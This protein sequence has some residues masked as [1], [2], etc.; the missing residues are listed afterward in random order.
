MGLLCGPIG[1]SGERAAERLV[2]G[3]ES[4]SRKVRLDT[5]ERL[6]AL[7]PSAVE[8]LIKA[9]ETGNDTV[10]YVGAQ[11][12][13]RIGDPRATEAL[14]RLTSHRHEHIRAVATEALGR[15]GDQQAVKPLIKGLTDP[16]AVV[17][18][19]AA[20]G[21]GHLR[22]ESAVDTLIGILF[23]DTDSEVRVNVI[24][25]L[26]MIHS[27][28]GTAR[29]SDS[30]I[31]A[32]EKAAQDSDENVR[33]VAVQCLGNMR[34]LTAVSILIDRL[35]DPNTNIRQE[36][37]RALGKIGDLRAVE[38][39]TELFSRADADEAVVVEKALENLTGR[40]YELER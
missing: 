30:L 13:G 15:L 35:E 6:V 21:L 32:M 27:R 18:R 1:C 40:D 14:V 20:L 24:R 8:A 12:L 23:L 11:I 26:A 29:A 34:D 22:A 19:E 39:L 5:G 10:Q 31:D 38:P 33:Y 25:S 28:M 2:K 17:R 4:P 16:F 7:G 9:I 37:A 3:L 36:A